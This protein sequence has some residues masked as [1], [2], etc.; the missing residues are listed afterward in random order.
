MEKLFENYNPFDDELPKVL[1]T[2]QVP[3]Q[4]QSEPIPYAVPVAQYAPIPQQPG[5]RKSTNWLMISFALS[6]IVLNSFVIYHFAFNKAKPVEVAQVKPEVEVP[7]KVEAPEAPKKEI[8]QIIPDDPDQEVPAV[9]KFDIKDI[10]KKVEAKQVTEVK[11]PPK[12]VVV[13]EPLEFLTPSE[14]KIAANKKGLPIITWV[15]FD[16]DDLAKP[17]AI[18][19]HSDL[20]KS[21][22]LAAIEKEGTVADNKGT[23]IIFTDK[24]GYPIYIQ[25]STLKDET[26][27]VIRNNIAEP[28]EVEVRPNDVSSKDDY[29]QIDIPKW[30]RRFNEGIKNPKHQGNCVWN[31]LDTLAM[32]HGYKDP[33]FSK[34]N[35]DGVEGT[36]TMST[37]SKESVNIAMQD[38]VAKAAKS[39]KD[40]GVPA[41]VVKG[42]AEMER[43]LKAGKPVGVAFQVSASGGH[44]LIVTGISKDGVWVVD[45]IDPKLR[46]RKLWIKFFFDR[47]CEHGV[48]IERLSEEIGNNNRQ[49]AKH[50]VGSDND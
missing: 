24:E 28:R 18:K 1:A 10:P 22:V 21:F 46:D 13:K 32:F 14:A 19:L 40:L 11:I 33:E 45:N 25:A 27:T 17:A 26:A 7:K 36:S 8:P 47:W 31:G 16:Q 30:C 34:N 4:I 37:G 29:P 9:P 48:I 38:V 35:F 41:K 2:K 39:L 6:I 50:F 20:K 3:V 12:K 5:A 49:E 42:R 43:A 23:R 44:F 15:G